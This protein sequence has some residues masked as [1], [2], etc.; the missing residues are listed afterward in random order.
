MPEAT[1]P[2]HHPVKPGFERFNSVPERTLRRV[3]AERKEQRLRESS[4]YGGS[5]GSTSA[6]SQ[7]TDVPE[8][9]VRR[10][11]ATNLREE[12]KPLV[13]PLSTQ[14]AETIEIWATSRSGQL[15]DVPPQVPP[16]SPRT[17]SRASPRSRKLPHAASSS[18]STTYSVVP[19]SS[20]VDT[21]PGRLYMAPESNS[22]L[23][24]LQTPSADKVPAP[25]TPSAQK[26]PE[27]SLQSQPKN[28]YPLP[29]RSTSNKG[30]PPTVKA[31]LRHQSGMSE[32]S[33]INRGR[34][35][36][37][38]DTSLIRSLSKPMLRS[39][40]LGKGYPDIPSGFKATEAPCR[41]PD[42]ESRYLKKQA[43]EQVEEFKVLPIKQVL[44]LTKVRRVSI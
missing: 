26:A 34:P 14:L 19:P 29:V 23:S 5:L 43:D 44:K 36:K 11:A 33:V 9:A 17:E 37:R 27:K 15:D 38:G 16:K 39:P 28:K 12:L 10:I 22:S 35:M 24:L 8:D 40:T 42:A 7:A 4:H 1:I 41:V 18:T 31:P 6:G 32:P 21:R 13:I 20:A 2:G 25:S 30:P 3:S